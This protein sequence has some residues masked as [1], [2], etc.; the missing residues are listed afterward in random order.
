MITQEIKDCFI[1]MKKDN[2]YSVDIEDG[3]W[4]IQEFIKEKT[5]QSINIIPISISNPISIQ[6]YNLALTKVFDHYLPLIEF[7][8]GT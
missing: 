4:L 1:K 7:A 8:D 3:C 2:I 6:L 5:G